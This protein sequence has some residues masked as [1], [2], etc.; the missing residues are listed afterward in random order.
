MVGAF[1]LEKYSKKKEIDNHRDT[2]YNGL[3]SGV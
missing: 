3:I 2:D 1:V